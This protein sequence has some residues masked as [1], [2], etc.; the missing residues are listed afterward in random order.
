MPRSHRPRKRYIPKRVEI[1][2]I[3]AAHARASLLPPASR[4]D[5]VRPMRAALDRLRAGHGDW[6]AWCA[7]ADCMNVAERLAEAGIASDRTA[8]FDAAQEALAG[9]LGVEARAILAP[10]WCAVAL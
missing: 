5:L 9:R 8:E 1:D 4:A 6:N 2:T 7:I 3:G 10:L